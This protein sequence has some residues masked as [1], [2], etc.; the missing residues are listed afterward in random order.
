[1]NDIFN[2]VNLAWIIPVAVT[3]LIV[4][5]LVLRLVRNSSTNRKLA[6]SGLDAEATVLNVRE[7]G[8]RINEQPQVTMTLDVKPANGMPSFQS[9][10]TRV[11]SYFQAAQFQPGS[12][13]QV[14]Y[15]PDNT[16][17]VAVVGVLGGGMSMGG[18]NSQQAVL[19]QQLIKANDLDNA[20]RQSGTSAQATITQKWDMGVM[21]NGSNPAVRLQVE[22][23]PTDRPAFQAQTIGVISAVSVSKFQPGATI[24]VKYDPNDI[25][26]VAIDHS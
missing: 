25:S 24:W 4:I 13:L 18:G 3:I 19:E 8:V 11:I 12:R 9:Q 7:T 2:I 23:H 21:V 17:Q 1:M 6:Q 14:K 20:L 5:P 26:R 15:D 22:V 10:A 16:A